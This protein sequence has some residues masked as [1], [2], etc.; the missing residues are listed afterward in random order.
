VRYRLTSP[1]MHLAFACAVLVAHEVND[2]AV[3]AASGELLSGH[4][5]KHVAAAFAALPVL[6]GL[7]PLAG[8]QNATGNVAPAA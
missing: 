3:L 2:H 6:A 1:E 7:A 5:L 8:R 4:T